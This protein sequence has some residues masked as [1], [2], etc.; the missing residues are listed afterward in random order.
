MYIMSNSFGD[1]WPLLFLLATLA[2]LAF[3][4]YRRHNP[5]P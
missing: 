3:P 2:G 4:R 1:Y 5:P